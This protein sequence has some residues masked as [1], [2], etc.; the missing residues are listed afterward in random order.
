MASSSATRRAVRSLSLA[1]SL[2]ALALAC[3]TAGA[4]GSRELQRIAYAGDDPL[5]YGEL[6]LPEGAGPFPL[7]IVIHGG[8]WRAELA[9]LDYVE[10]LAEA[11]RRAGVATWNIEYRR[12][13]DAG[14]G[15]PGTF[16]DVAA[17]TDFVRSLAHDH[18]I[19][20]ARVVAIGHSAGAQLALWDLA[21]AK[22]PAKSALY[23]ASP[24]PLHGALALG[25]PGDLRGIATAADSFCGGGVIEALLGGTERAV[26]A[27]YAEAS[28]AALLPLGLP[29]V[30]VTGS[31]DRIMPPRAAAPYVRAA[32]DSGDVAELVEIRGASHFD[33]VSPS[34]RA[35][36]TV[37]AKLLELVAPAK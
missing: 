8:C 26:P 11:L 24:L 5:Q 18:P 12:V 28:A 21:R 34:S 31:D 33:L 19:D 14:G 1:L 6:R 32:K 17:A 23:R 30:L 36:P 22:L 7:A 27:H 15:W 37:K 20:L 16:R 25:G 29:Q 13:G 35:W 2:C 4:Q 10:P 3:G 9:T